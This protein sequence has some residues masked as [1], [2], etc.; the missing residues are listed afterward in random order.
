MA[1]FRR[2][3]AP[4]FAELAPAD[5]SACARLHGAA[6]AHGWSELDFERLLAAA[7]AS[8]EAAF[9]SAGLL[10]FVLSRVALDEAE[11]LTMVVASSSRRRGIGRNLL[12]RHLERLA[13]ARV[14]ALFLEVGEDNAAA[15]GLYGKLGF[16]EVGRRPGYYPMGRD[17]PPVDAIVLRRPVG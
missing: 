6:F 1:L 9:T 4:R 10:G 13:Q 7:N 14:R 8:S 16:E 15:R 2:P 11:V 17:G 12:Q 5:A 3:A